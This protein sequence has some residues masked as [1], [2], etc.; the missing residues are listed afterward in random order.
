MMNNIIFDATFSIHT[1]SKRIFRV[2]GSGPNL[3]V[4]WNVPTFMCH[5]YGLDFSEV[6]TRW[7]IV[8]NSGDVFRGDNMVILYDPGEFPA[9]LHDKHGQLKFRNGGVPQEGNLTRH[10]NKLKTQIDELVPDH[11]FKG[12]IN[13]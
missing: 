11:N 13:T 1:F 2:E 12:E 5:R 10:L 7:G 8:Q 4:F 9:L 6:H 3:Q